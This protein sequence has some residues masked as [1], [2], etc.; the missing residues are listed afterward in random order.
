MLSNF[1]LLARGFVSD[2]LVISCQNRH[3]W[4]LFKIKLVSIWECNGILCID[5]FLIQKIHWILLLI[6]FVFYFSTCAIM[7][8]K[9]NESF[10]F[11]F[12][13]LSS[14]ISFWLTGLACISMSCLIKLMFTYIFALFL[15]SSYMTST[16]TFKYDLCW[17]L[18]CVWE[19]W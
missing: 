1:L 6:L 2:H 10:V 12:S 9:N 19:V 5:F 13:V 8:L 3:P 18:E 11:S 14:L 7:T 17:S 16:F 15:V 4:Y